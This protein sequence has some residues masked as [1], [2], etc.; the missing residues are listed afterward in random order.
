MGVAW[1]HEVFFVVG[2]YAENQF[3]V[4]RIAGHKRFFPESVL[5]DIEPQLGLAG[6]L[7]R[8]VT[9]EAILG[10]ERPHIAVIGKRRGQRG[11]G[12]VEEERSDGQAHGAYAVARVAELRKNEVA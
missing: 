11:Q 8:A 2:V 4:V 3:G 10:Q 12:S 7:V 5:A 9:G 1:W 6:I